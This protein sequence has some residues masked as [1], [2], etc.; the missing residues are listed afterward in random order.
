MY[1]VSH[2]ECLNELMGLPRLL[3]GKG[4]AGQSGDEG[5]IPGCG[6]DPLEKEMAPTPVFLP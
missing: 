2:L 3:S 4:S 1:L 6:E 5:L